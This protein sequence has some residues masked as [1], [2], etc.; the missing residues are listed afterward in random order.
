MIITIKWIEL[1]CGE[2]CLSIHPSL[3][4]H[5]ISTQL[6]ESKWSK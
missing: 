3:N 1:S 6:F 4:E 2:Q 5:E